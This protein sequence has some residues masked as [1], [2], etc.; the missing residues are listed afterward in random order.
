MHDAVKTCTEVNHFKIFMEKLYSLYSMS[1]K[2]RRSLPQ[3]AAEV[4]CELLKIG[5]VLDVR[6]VA[7]TY[8]AVKAVWVSYV[9]LYTL[10]FDKASADNSLDSKERSQYKGMAS[11]LS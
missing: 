6:W 10:H 5:R 3:C 7:P 1:P 8:R 2:N 11:K 4:G 9:A